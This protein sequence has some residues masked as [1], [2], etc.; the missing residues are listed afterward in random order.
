MR[1][2]QGVH[3]DPTGSKRL[4]GGLHRIGCTGNYGLGGAVFVGR[5]HVP[6]NLRKDF[7]HH[8][9]A[10]CNPRHLPD[11]RDVHR[12][13]FPASSTDCT[14]R[15]GELHHARRHHRAVLPQGVSSDHIWHHTIAGQEAKN[16]HIHGQGRRLG[17]LR[18][19]QRFKRG[20]LV[21]MDPTCNVVHQ[22]MLQLPFHDGAGFLKGLPHHLEF[23]GQIQAHPNVLAALTGKEKGQLSIARGVLEMDALDSD[24]VVAAALPYGLPCPLQLLQHLLSVVVGSR[25]THA[26]RRLESRGLTSFKL[27]HAGEKLRRVLAAH[28]PD[29]RRHRTTGGVG[30]RCHG[31]HHRVRKLPLG[32]TMF[33]ED[34]VKVGAPKSKRTHARNPFPA[35]GPPRLRLGLHFQRHQVQ[36]GF[37][38]GL[39]EVDAGRQNLVV[40]RKGRLQGAGRAG[41]A[42][43]VPNLGLHRSNAN[44]A[45]VPTASPANDLGE[46]LGLH[47]VPH[48][49][50]GA[51]A[52]HE[53]HLHRVNPRVRVRPA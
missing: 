17:D 43:E 46:S 50:G 16:R 40:N 31:L 12:G 23:L 9:G 36:A 28:S 41:R 14:E 24:Q 33:P 21:G 30:R 45:P 32:P 35:C 19:P 25:E 20:V 34:H 22:G 53:V 13:H 38:T 5:D 39:L 27:V 26:I 2:R 1:D 6:G 44:G 37:G 11:V 10:G 18:G 4:A 47:L 15:I 48:H 52:L 8:P 49:G 42:L 7:F 3:G 29:S 51:V